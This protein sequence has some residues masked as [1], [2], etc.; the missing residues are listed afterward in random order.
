MTRAPFLLLDD[1]RQGDDGS[2]RLYENPLEIVVARRED[3]VAAALDRIAATPGWWAGALA[4]KPGWRWNAAP[5][6]RAAARPGR[7]CG[8][9]ALRG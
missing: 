7:W 3:E 2:A 6:R 9:P 1:A 4:M 8:L 5:A